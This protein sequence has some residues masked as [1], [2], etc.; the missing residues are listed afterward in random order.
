[1]YAEKYEK[2]LAHFKTHLMEDEKS[3]ATIEKYERDIKKFLELL[4][5]REISKEET[6]AYKCY[7]TENYAPSS[8]NSM[9]VAL[10]Q[11]LRYIGRA[12]CCVKQLKIQRNVFAS[13][14]KELT[15][16][17]YKKLL[18]AAGSSRLA[19]IMQTICGTG[20]RISELKYITVEAVKAGKAVIQCKG[21]TRVI[22]I[23]NHL[24]TILKKYIRKKGIRQGAVFVTRNGNPLDRSN[25]W[26]MM[27]KLCEKAQVSAQKVFPHNL[28]HL[29]A[30][31]FYS[32]EKDVVRLADVLGHSSIDT[33]RIYTMETGGQH[34]YLL[35]RVHKKLTT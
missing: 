13:E 29:F 10:N 22:L 25:L 30:R 9:L 27:K 18:E 14:E 23:P 1:M 12:E 7:L 5:E 33:T 32:I 26:K 3:I 31:T 11:F 28:R 19:V 34:R 16:S 4:G 6:V 35:E 17:E 8:T 2:K 21:K 15:K 20:I 24:R